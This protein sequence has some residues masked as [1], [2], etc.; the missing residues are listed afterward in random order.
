V[1]PHVRRVCLVTAMWRFVA[2]DK[3]TRHPAQIY[4]CLLLFLPN[5]SS[6]RP[7]NHVRSPRTSSSRSHVTLF[8]NQHA[9]LLALWSP[10]CHWRCHVFSPAIS[11]PLWVRVLTLPRGFP[12]PSCFLIKLPF[13]SPPPTTPCQ[14]IT[15]RRLRARN[16]T[17]LV[18]LLLLEMR[19]GAMVHLTLT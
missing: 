10:V 3:R 16:S 7:R 9:L 17:L 19:L 11:L 18:R 6:L 14:N 4:P 8:A 5:S 1:G 15:T 12:C 2:Q 13:S